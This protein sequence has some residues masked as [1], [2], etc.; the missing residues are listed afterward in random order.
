[1]GTNKHARLIAGTLFSS[2][3]RV[4][5]TAV[6][7]MKDDFECDAIRSRRSRLRLSLLKRQRT[8][9]TKTEFHRSSESS[10]KCG[11]QQILV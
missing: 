1:M 4:Y 6:G 9:V 5:I 7:G 8:A 3:E 2:T 10:L 11:S